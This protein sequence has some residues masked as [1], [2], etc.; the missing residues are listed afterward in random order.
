MVT[1]V[2]RTNVI[3]ILYVVIVVVHMWDLRQRVLCY[4]ICDR[5]CVNLPGGAVI[6]RSLRVEMDTIHI[7][8][9]IGESVTCNMTLY[10]CVYVRVSTYVCLGVSTRVYVY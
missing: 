6:S 9:D 8:S 3:R 2:V 5:K 7:L 1:T 10:M 4:R